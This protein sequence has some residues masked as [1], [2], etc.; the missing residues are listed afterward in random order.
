MSGA[1]NSTNSQRE[2]I[3]GLL[4]AELGLRVEDVERVR[5]FLEEDLVG[6]SPD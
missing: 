3:E 2:W 5:Q 4:R 6:G 1:E